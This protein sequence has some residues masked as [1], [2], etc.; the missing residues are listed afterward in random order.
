MLDLVHPWLLI[1]LPM[2]LLVHWFVPAWR[3]A[4]P[5]VRVSFMA[6]L[7]RLTGRE[8][9]EGSAVARSGLLRTLMLVVCWVLL[10]L[11]LARPQWLEAPLTRDIPMR[12]MLVAVDL[13]GS[14]E[15]Q[16]FT[17]INGNLVDRLTAV[18]EVLDGFLARRE[19]DRIGLIVFGT[20]AFVQAPFTDDLDLIRTLLDEVELRM[21]GARTAIGDAMGLAITLFERSEVEERVLILLTDGNDTGS[22]IPPEEAAGIARDNDI[23]V[24]TIG[25][26]DPANAGEAPLDETTLR[27]VA[28]TTGGQYFFAADREGLEDVYTE[29]DRLTPRNV[30]TLTHRPR[31]DLFHWPL[32]LALLLTMFYHTAHL[33]SGLLSRRRLTAAEPS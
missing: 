18:K 33:I 2:P 8:P 30:E 4:R 1:L 23:V 6:R 29:L 15:T 12:D 27:R 13:S 9:A 17:D 25:I 22:L 32:G 5:A 19:D 20:G 16:D 14:M 28:T 24:Y 26:G 31:R 10:V 11:A 7:S 3:E 21:A